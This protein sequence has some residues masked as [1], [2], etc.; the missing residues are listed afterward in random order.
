MSSVLEAARV[1]SIFELLEWEMPR[2]SGDDWQW[3]CRN[4]RAE[5]TRISQR[6]LFEHASRPVKD[7]NTVALNAATKERLRFHLGQMRGIIEKDATPGWKKQDLYEAIAELEREIDKART[8]LAAVFDVFGKA[9]EGSETFM[10]TLRK[11]VTIIQDAKVTESQSAMLAA[12]V[13]PKRIEAPKPKVLAVTK[14][15]KN[16]FD[17]ALDD[18]IPF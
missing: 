18:E 12:P 10:D 14:S 17:K 15:K 4:F 2:R 16:G 6:I 11:V 9:L 8:R 5:A 7:P 1:C 13:E 3:K